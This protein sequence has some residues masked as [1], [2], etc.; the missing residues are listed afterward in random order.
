MT[1]LRVELLGPPQV[2]VDDDPL[3]VD[4]R[5]AVAVLARLVVDGTQRRD[6][7]TS[8]LWPS[9]DGTRARAALRRTLSALNKGLD[10][11]WIDADRDEVRLQREDVA[12]DVMEFDR[13]RATADEHEH[14]PDPVC[15]S[16]YEAL[17]A[18]ASLHRGEFM[19]GFHLRNC[20][21]FEDWRS[22][23]A[24]RQRR[25]LSEVLDW[26]IDVAVR[27]NELESAVAH[28]QRRLELEPLHEPTHRR[29]MLV[30]A[31]RGQRGA[32]MRQYRRCVAV[33]ENELGVSP[34]E[35]T[36]ALHEAIV[37]GEAPD[38][39]APEPV[40]APTRPARQRTEVPFVGRSAALERLRESYEQSRRS[41]QLVWI[42]GEAGIGKSRLTGEFL[43]EIKDT[44]HSVAAVGCYE[45]EQTVAYSVMADLLRAVGAAGSL[46]DVSDRW[47][48]EA[49]RFAPELLDHRPDLEPSVPAT[50]AEGRRRL[51]E[52][53][54]QIIVSALPKAYPGIVVIEDVQWVDE[55]SADALAYLLRRIEGARICVIVTARAGL[56][57]EEHPVA[58]VVDVLEAS[59][60]AERIRL[61]RFH[62][63]E[64]RA[65]SDAMDVPLGS[66]EVDRLVAESEGVPLVAVEYLEVLADTDR[67][68]DTWGVPVGI[69]SVFQRQIDRVSD[70]ARQVL[71]AA[72]V[73]G[74][75]FDLDLLLET[76]GRDV[77]EAV[78]AIEELTAA[79]LLSETTGGVEPRYGFRHRKL[80]D[81]TYEDIS[82]VRRRLLHGRVATALRARR[83]RAEGAEAQRPSSG[84]LA[85]HLRAAGKTEDAASVYVDAADEAAAL[86]AHAEAIAQLRAALELGHPE[87]GLLHRRLGDLLTLRGDYRAALQ[88]YARAAA[89]LE[90]PVS[91]ARIEHRIAGV[92]ERSGDWESAAAHIE[93]GLDVLP[94][95]A[96]APLLAR[97]RTDRAL[98]AHRRG[99]RET[100]REEAQGAWAIAEEVDDDPAK[101]QACN[102]L[103]MLARAS[104]DPD[105]AV[106]HLET[107]LEI[108]GSIED[109]APR[110][111][112]LNNLAL[113]K[114]DRGERPAG[115][116]LAKTALGLCRRHG[117][118]H[119]EAA[120]LNN[121]ADLLHDAGQREESLQYLKQAVRLF[122][123]VG[124][125]ER[126]E[127]AIW[128]LVDW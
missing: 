111:A 119:R 11:R 112:S 83:D 64:V 98:V 121:L 110:I 32:A 17:A 67:P 12:A 20:P 71:S 127:P 95:D 10:A 26:L 14:G 5:K 104:G 30:Y 75:S 38:P 40:R 52:A 85:H 56:L 116:E 33:L 34:L 47:L 49:G 39:P 35:R 54:R 69:R 53:A 7:L 13:L 103:G 114:A 118:R 50:R 21:P 37:A 68:D 91:V 84:L 46:D 128:K 28:A 93:A 96:P 4:T 124:P 107:S 74:R 42:E 82:A 59:G 79:G 3:Q 16:C 51:L 22:T 45:E 27:R 105:A 120:I 61:E 1:G 73:I 100:A 99:D 23:E 66:D 113:A 62:E 90:A 60:Q 43:R 88:A 2:E 18:A 72:A 58:G 126:H 122:A 117:D 87:R 48:E 94:D 55:A 97:L 92:H 78:A 57:G 115:L 101:A 109:P 41:G 86:S 70:A 24:E 80:R 31:W 6:A 102:L 76:S 106:E 63:D 8:W 15:G 89:H 77:E 81:V 36:V 29:L 19:E 65:L 25:R 9:S 108:A 44:G 125:P 123:E